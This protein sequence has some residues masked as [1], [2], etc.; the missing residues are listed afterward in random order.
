MFYGNGRITGTV[1]LNYIIKK[2]NLLIFFKGWQT[3]WFVLEKDVLTYY[4]SQ[5]E[6][7]QGCRGSIKVHACEINGTSEHHPFFKFNLTQ[8]IFVVHQ[9]D[10]TRMDLVI[11]GEQH[12]YLRAATSQERQQ[13]LVALGTA[14]ACV[15]HSKQKD[16]GNCH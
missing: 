8:I 3:R 14:K 2:R 15:F 12:L 7:K 9:I 5:E 16:L 1:K 6:V 10:S 13:W 4:K 11:P